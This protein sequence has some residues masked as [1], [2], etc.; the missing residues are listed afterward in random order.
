MKKIAAMLCMLT[1]VFGLTA[2]GSKEAISD[3]ENKRCETA[4]IMAT[5]FVVPFMMNF[6]DDSV[7]KQY[8][9]DYNVHELEALTENELSY[10][11]YFYSSYG[12][13]YEF[14]AIDVDGIA[15]LNGITSFN[16]TYK[17]LGEVDATNGLTAKS[18]V[19]GDKIIVT[20]PLTGTLT[21]KKGNLRTA[22]AELIFSN[23]IFLKVESCTLNLNQ[24]IGELMGKAAMDTVMGMGT[25]FAVLILISLIIWAMGG[26]P[27][28]QEKL[29]KKNKDEVQKLK[30]DAVD[31]T[32][33]Q[34]IEKEER[35]GT[36]EDLELAAVIAAAVAA[37][38]GAAGADGFVVRSIRKRR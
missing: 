20:V 23:D 38:E 36:T 10:Y 7:A 11:L 18:E 1:C 16:S 13:N 15:I 32:I 35:V 27:K 17:S 25:V 6:F 34:I 4:K 33:A 22:E 21:D 28:L 31:N 9:T 2:C 30:E 24:S 37:Y 26:I 29:K 8:Q 12:I 3:M 19:S 14:N 5:D